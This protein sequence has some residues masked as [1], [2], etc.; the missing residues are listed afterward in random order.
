MILVTGGAGFIG[1]RVTRL[2][3]E[4]GRAVRVLDDLSGGHPA[5]T[6]CEFTLGDVTDLEALHR[7]A[8]G[9]EVIVHL[10][11]A[12]S[13]TACDTSPIIAART[14]VTGTLNVITACERAGARLV[15]ASSAAV[16]V[17]TA[18]PVSEG[19]RVQPASLYGATKQVGEAAALAAGGTALRLFNA[20]HP[21]EGDGVIARWNRAAASGAPLELRGDGN[22]I[23]DYVHVD[24]VAAVI[25]HFVANPRRGVLNVCTGLGTS[26]NSLLG[27]IRRRHGRV[28][29]RRE[30]RRGNDVSCSV[31]DATRLSVVASGLRFR[32][33]EEGLA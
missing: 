17:E 25:A 19:A 21:T 6:G 23:R 26:L 30:P 8:E 24:D 29:V 5:P 7:A 22:Q 16:Y 10:A 28:T 2:L 1:R 14:N 12:S 15:F 9:A 11:A 13:V 27:V 4:T 31:G 18:N 20:Y 3:R 32:T 33:I